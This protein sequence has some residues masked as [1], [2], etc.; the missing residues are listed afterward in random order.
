MLGLNVFMFLLALSFFLTVFVRFKVWP[1]FFKKTEAIFFFVALLGI[2][3]GMWFLSS[4]EPGKSIIDRKVVMLSA[5]SLAG[6]IASIKY[7]IARKAV[8]DKE[9][10]E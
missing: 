10:S 2:A 8:N 4:V 7:Q 3:F 5:V 9:K 6:L 1:D